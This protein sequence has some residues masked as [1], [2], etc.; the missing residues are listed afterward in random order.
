MQTSRESLP[1]R[2][3]E[4]S[5]PVELP[6]PREIPKTLEMDTHDINS[7]VIAVQHEIGYEI[8][9]AWWNENV[10][11]GGSV[12][13]AQ[14]IF[15]NF[16]TAIKRDYEADFWRQHSVPEEQIAAVQGHE[17]HNADQNNTI[18]QINGITIPYEVARGEGDPKIW[19]AEEEHRRLNYVFHEAE[20][21]LSREFQVGDE[22]YIVDSIRYT[23]TDG[24]YE[25]LEIK[26]RNTETSEVSN[27][28]EPEEV[29]N[30][31]T[32]SERHEEFNDQETLYEIVP[33]ADETLNTLPRDAL[34]LVVRNHCN[35]E[36]QAPATAV[37]DKEVTIKSINPSF[38]A[39]IDINT[40]REEA[41]RDFIERVG[42]DDDP[43]LY[44]EFIQ[45]LGAYTSSIQTYQQQRQAREQAATQAAYDL[46]A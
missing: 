31:I 10:Q 34:E 14:A 46:A 30:I 6:K 11:K 37:D 13:D 28:L 43:E 27:Y 7:A 25:T 21:H 39:A 20:F 22:T 16:D 35:R 23:G 45:S 3:L 24:T 15:A 44:D 17:D 12:N 32:A 19:A 8:S 29:Q 40:F 36:N 5:S 38:T 18:Q 1:T 33:L 2:S 4:Q 42:I 26:I 9:P 41:I